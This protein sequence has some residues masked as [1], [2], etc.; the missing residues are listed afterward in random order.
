MFSRIALWLVIRWSNRPFVQPFL[1]RFYLR[2]EERL[3]LR[4]HS[5][6]FLVGRDALNHQTCTRITG[7]KSL[8]G[9]TTAK[10]GRNRI[11]S[12]I[13]FLLQCSMASEATRLEDRPNRFEIVVMFVG[14]NRSMEGQSYQENGNR[15]E[16]LS[17]SK[18][19]GLEEAHE[20][21]RSGRGKDGGRMMP[22]S[23]TIISENP[24]NWQIRG[25]S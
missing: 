12:Q 1:D 3:S 24:G 20:E 8:S 4:W 9:I 2:R 19:V 15:L 7:L 10:H 21:L 5:R 17:V 25:Q 6:R 13:G 11:Q 18:P 22:S 23:V 16:K 14:K